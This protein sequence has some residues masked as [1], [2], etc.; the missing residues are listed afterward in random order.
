MNQPTKLLHGPDGKLI[1]SKPLAAVDIAVIF[2]PP[3]SGQAR[4]IQILKAEVDGDMHMIQNVLSGAMKKVIE[5]LI[6]LGILG[7]KPGPTI[8]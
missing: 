3:G 1:S 6:Q 4:R 7:N 5:V 2:K 8:N